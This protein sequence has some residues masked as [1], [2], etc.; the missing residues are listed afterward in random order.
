MRY[1]ATT[2]ILLM[3]FTTISHTTQEADIVVQAISDARK[4]A[5]K[6]IS[7]TAWFFTGCA[8]SIFGYALALSSYSEIPI[9]RFMG[10]SP[11]YV[12][13]YIDEYYRKS[14]GIK[15]NSAF[16]GWIFGVSVAVVFIAFNQSN[17]T[18]N[19]LIFLR[20]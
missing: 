8:F 3:L 20:R 19:T 9:E 10:K 14:K 1:I 17:K 6:D 15:S 16:L 11:E 7:K 12:T 18:Y 5:E 2:L 13:I 4:D